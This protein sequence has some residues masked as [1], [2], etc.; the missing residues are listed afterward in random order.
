[1]AADDSEV[2]HL[3]MS[4][5]SLTPTFTQGLVLGQLSIF[6]LL[7]L[8]VRYLFLDSAKNDPVHTPAPL[9]ARISLREA[10][11]EK[12]VVEN[13]FRMGDAESAEW[14]NLLLQM[15]CIS[16]MRFSRLLS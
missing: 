11:K 6:L 13:D 9:P 12:A 3:N 7:A 10:E 8:I 4:L 2:Q 14:F 5:F 1:M 16:L 15:V